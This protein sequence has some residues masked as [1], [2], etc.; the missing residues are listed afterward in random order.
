MAIFQGFW[1]S[2]VSVSQYRD[3]MNN[4][5]TWDDDLFDEEISTSEEPELPDWSIISE[6]AFR[7]ARSIGI[8]PSYAD[9]VAQI[10]VKKLYTRDLKVRHW[11]AYV[12]TMVKNQTFD[13]VRSRDYK[14]TSTGGIPEAGSPQW[15]GVR[16]LMGQPSEIFKPQDVGREIASNDLYVRILA[17]VPADKREMFIDHLEGVRHAELAKIYGY[18]SAA[19]VT[20]I[21][22]RIKKSLRKRFQFD[23][24]FMGNF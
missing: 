7:Q 18:A 10:V 24:E 11:K 5:E 17:E 23:D 22:G 21:I 13:Y 16:D 9:D 15:F 1:A 3:G 20:Q 19:S 14:A 12:R 2:F 6:Y 4:D 8:D